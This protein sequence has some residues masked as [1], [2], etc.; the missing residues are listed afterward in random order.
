MYGSYFE[1]KD[2]ATASSKKDDLVR[3]RTVSLRIPVLSSL[4]LAAVITR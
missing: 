4:R 1:G 3:N 2:D